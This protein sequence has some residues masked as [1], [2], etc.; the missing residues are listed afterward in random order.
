VTRGR[1]PRLHFTARSGWIN[2]PHGIT[3]RDGRYHVFYQ[4]VPDSTVW[5]PDC[6][7]G[8]AMGDDL[9]HLEELPV[10][11]EPGDGDDGVWT[12]T[13]VEDA[14]AARILYTAV[15]E[16]GIGIGRIRTA[17]PR[18]LDWRQWRKGQ[19]VATAP[20]ELDLVAFR[21][22]FVAREGDVWRMYVGAGSRDGTAMALHYR[23]EN[24]ADWTYEGVTAQRS[25]H[26][27]EPLWTGS[28][29][30]CPQV[31]AFGGAHVLVFSIWE[32]DVLHHVG[33]GV[34]DLR[35][36]VFS[37]RAWGRL[38]F[39]PSYYAPSFFH[40]TDGRPCLIFWMR[41]I[42]DVEAGWAGA[43]SI[44]YLLSLD[45]DVLVLTRHPD[46]D[47]RLAE[48]AADGDASVQDIAWDPE[49]TPSL[50]VRDEGRVVAELSVSRGSIE[51]SGPFTA[52]CPRA[53]SGLVR[54]LVDGPVLEVLVDGVV[55]G[56]PLGG[57][58][59]PDP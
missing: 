35:D 23:S 12:G 53:G 16:P 43:H 20:A 22:P 11:L 48:L 21:D 47:A 54:V 3:V 59:P 8:H 13:L 29:W 2:D 46:V 52:S 31:F 33:Y 36:G 49:L 14:G 6:R 37:A 32:D 57:A 38:T 15:T 1:R 27:H 58:V 9:L 55:T 17:V 44:P 50:S 42:E 28:L 56:G 34:G 7:W 5:R 25:T 45:G 10:A 39:G 30:E 41:G 18:D 51:I 19:V 4:C 40:D 24:L 26:E